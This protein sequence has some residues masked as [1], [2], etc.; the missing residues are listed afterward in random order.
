MA[1]ISI[2][3][4]LLA[5]SHFVASFEIVQVGRLPTKRGHAA[6]VFDGK[7]SVFILGGLNQSPDRPAQY[8]DDVLQFNITAETIERVARL[9]IPIMSAAAGTDGRGLCFQFGG[10]NAV[11][12]E[13]QSTIYAF[14]AENPEPIKVGD[15]PDPEYYHSTASDGHGAIYILGGHGDPV[16]NEIFKFNASTLS[17]EQVGTAPDR[18]LALAS[19]WVGDSVYGFGGANFSLAETGQIFKFTPETG[20]VKVMEAGLQGGAIY[21][22]AVAVG[23]DVYIIGG[24]NEHDG[25]RFSKFNTVVETL[26]ELEVTNYSTELLTPGAVYVPKT[27]RIY[28]FGGAGQN[29][30][31]NYDEIFYIQL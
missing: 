13:H 25:F 29:V 28:V 2:V 18:L 23:E 20:A 21:S 1:S 15:L 26:E 12:G 27:N 7:D 19:A 8:F 11:T 17:I 24:I 3:L 5:L 6:S 16:P 31:E 22:S 9:P 30:D 10:Y 4:A 14:S